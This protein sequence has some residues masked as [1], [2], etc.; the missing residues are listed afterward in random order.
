MRGIRLAYIHPAADRVD[1]TFSRRRC[2][3]RRHVH[4][5]ARTWKGGPNEPATLGGRNMTKIK[6]HGGTAREGE[7]A[8]CLSCRYAAIVQGASAQNQIIRGSPIGALIN[9][10]V[11]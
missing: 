9:F 3:R 7:S 10:T 6:I 2:H 5:A 8:L 1:L 4:N 11:V